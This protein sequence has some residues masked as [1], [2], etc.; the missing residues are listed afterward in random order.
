MTDA[1]L[2]RLVREMRIERRM[3]QAEMSE[4]MGIDQ[5]RLSRFENG[6]G[7]AVEVGFLAEV[8]DALGV[9]FVLEL[10]A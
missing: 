7:P 10:R 4:V 5:S 6:K 8:A 9:E 3:T 1:E 2:G